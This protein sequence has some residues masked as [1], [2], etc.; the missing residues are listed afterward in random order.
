MTVGGQAAA[1]CIVRS[2]DKGASTST[3]KSV[4]HCRRE[5]LADAIHGK[6]TGTMCRCEKK[7]RGWGFTKCSS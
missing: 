7:G 1:F 5:R 4:L 2:R 3:R 6:M